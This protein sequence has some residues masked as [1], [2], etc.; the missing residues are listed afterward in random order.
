MYGPNAF[1]S[2]GSHQN[3]LPWTQKLISPEIGQHQSCNA[4][5][6]QKVKAEFENL[7]T[8]VGDFRETKF[9]M[10]CDL[11]YENLLLTMDG[12]KRVARLH[13]RNID[14]VHLEKKAIRIAALNFEIAEGK[15]TSVAS[16]SIR[17]ELGDQAE[18]WYKELWD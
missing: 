2:Y 17:I 1:L 15:V 4:M 7:Q 12:G 8:S 3:G 9:L 14:N 13:A 11:A 5:K 10:K 16:G 18:A 6:A